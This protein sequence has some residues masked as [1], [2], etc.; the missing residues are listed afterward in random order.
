MSPDRI[1]ERGPEC[2]V[3][4]EPIR[5][6]CAGW[7]IPKEASGWFESNGTHLKRYSQVF[8]ACEINSSFYRPH[9]NKT[10]ERW[11]DSA[12]D[13][14]RFSVK[15]PRSITHEAKLK[16]TAEA[17]Q[18]FIRQISFLREKLGPM[19]VQLPPRLEFDY[20][21]AK[22]FLS[23]LRENYARDVVWEPR[24]GS[25]F[26][27]VANDLLAGFQVARVA[28]D[29]AC[30]PAAGSPGGSTHLTYYRLHGSPRVYYSNYTDDLLESLAEHFAM[31]V[32][33]TQVWCVFDNTAAGCAIRNAL[34]LKVKLKSRLS[35]QDPPTH[36]RA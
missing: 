23:L 35:L 16:C 12:P 10:W 5:I 11:A 17:L 25:W 33:K 28:A 4:L 18:A 19:L 21:S 27:D 1:F 9:Q 26:C 20:V 3:E 22:R 30:V 24:H 34:D 6:G 14:F 31:L 8:N 13:D 36:N 32:R 15:A 7:S 29:P 2:S